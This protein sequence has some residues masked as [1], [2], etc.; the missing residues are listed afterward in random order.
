MTNTNLNLNRLKNEK[1]LY[2]R[3]HLSNPIHWWAYGPEAIEAARAENKPI[4][5]S[6]GYSSCHWCHVM[7]HDSFM[8]VEIA[9][10]LN[11]NFIC[12]KVDREEYP[13]LD[14]YYQ[15]AAQLFSNN[16]GWPLSAFLLPDMRP[17]FVG[18]YFPA[19]S[20][21]GGP[22]FSDL[23][24]EL[25]RAF[26]QEKEQV[27]KNASQVTEAIKNGNA[28][29][30]KVQFEGHFP[31]PNGILEAIKEFRDLE[32]GG[33][34]TAPK[35][36]HF[37]FFEWAIEQM[38]EGMV[39]REQ[40]EFIISSMEKMLMGGINDHARGGIHRYST[41]EKWLV[42]HFEKMLYD[43]AGF[44]KLL[45][46]LSL[47]HPSPLVFDSII[48]TL[49]YLE[50]EMLAD[51]GTETSA[52]Y[53]FASQDADSEGVEGLYFTFSYA[54]F[55]DLLNKSDN[56]KET[57]AKNMDKIKK[58]FQ[59]TDKGNFEH[60]LNIISLDPQ[61][62]DEYFLQE[63]WDIIRAVRKT[64]V[65]ERKE[66]IPPAT[67]NKGVASWNFMMVSALVDVV[68][69]SQVEVIKRMSSNL[70][71]KV[72]EGIFKTFLI[73]DPNG[74]K[75]RHSTTM[76]YSHPYL[77]DFVMFAESQI[78]LYE[79]SG[80]SIFKQNFQDAMIFISK[81]F[82]DGN[83]MLTRARLSEEFELYPNQEYSIFDSSFKSPVGTFIILSRR[84][85][86]LF[87]DRNYQDVIQDLQEN[88]T[89][90][91]LKINPVSS[92]E[93]LRGL[94]YPSEV[95][96]VMKVPRVWTQEE[97]FIK[98]I[99]FF[100]TRFVIDYHDENNEW[101]ICTMNACE[102]KGHGIE[103]FVTT[104]NPKEEGAN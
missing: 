68:Q 20:K 83:K 78:R 94:T 43:Q 17:F 56:E 31:P 53:F 66:R 71:N 65:N 35:F 89:H 102:L 64:I 9:K 101:Q 62:K 50:D 74:I 3:Q 25:R 58:W 63:N 104:L 19:V 22:N 8:N 80:N 1:S 41:D 47:V 57:L 40:G 93:A 52:K 32:W 59:I 69:Y 81:E 12:I 103:E 24:K 4:F 10:Q 2:L 86:V 45:S 96:R 49:N 15:K 39:S 92:G 77:E 29:I 6:V 88:V 18:T 73:Q 75:M 60:N 28:N 42:P 98:M 70:L 34:G 91:V 16:G 27:E 46:K 30:E 87:S 23:L 67:D 72:I 51:D 11:E 21:D 5:L 61:F 54:E 36:P 97:N 99:P 79:I 100:L 13:D 33:Y 95:Y 48:N 85:A 76:P 38:L 90:T 37:A 7:A 55:E 84:A 26:D 44:L 14:N 82:L